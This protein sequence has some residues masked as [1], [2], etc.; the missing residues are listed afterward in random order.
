MIHDDHNR[1]LTPA[2]ALAVITVLVVLAYGPGLNGPQVFDDF[3]NLPAL[4]MTTGSWQEWLEKSFS[5]HSGLLRRPL[6]NFTFLVNDWLSELPVAQQTLPY[7]VTN[8]LIHLLNGLLVYL[9]VVRLTMLLITAEQGRKD[10]R[11]AAVTVAG[12]WLLHPLQVSSV[13]YLVQRMAELAVTFDLLAVLLYLH[14][15]ADTS[16]RSIGRGVLRAI[17][18]LILT[19]LAGLSKENGLLLPLYLVAIEMVI[20]TRS[21]QGSRGPGLRAFRLMTIV[22]PL[23][24]GIGALA[25]YFPQLLTNYDIRPFSMAERLLTEQM[26]LL[27]YWRLI[28]LPDLSQMNLLHDNYPVARE[29]SLSIAVAIATHA[30]LLSTAVHTPLATFNVRAA[31]QPPTG[32]SA[33]NPLMRVSMMSWASCC[34]PSAARLRH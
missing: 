21:D 31:S 25:I 1:K 30:A 18:I 34:F 27:D 12:L 15:R 32:Q 7:K 9:V 14:F 6:A 20:A 13:L 19:L 10:A 16:A 11:L 17:P 4:T 26:V 29:I 3:V 8:L 33:I 5:N 22:L 28:L 24:V 23:T 2:V